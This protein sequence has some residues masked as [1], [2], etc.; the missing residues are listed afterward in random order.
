MDAEIASVPIFGLRHSTFTAKTQIPRHGRRQAERWN[1]NVLLVATADLRGLRNIDPYKFCQSTSWRP[2][3]MDDVSFVFLRNTPN[4]SS[5]IN[6]LQI[7]CSTQV[8]DPPVAASRSALHEF[9]L[10]SGELFF[11]LHRD[12]DAEKS[13]AQA[14]MLYRDDPNV[15]L[16][17]GLL[18][19]RQQ[20]YRGS[21]AGIAVVSGD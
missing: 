18:F 12:R 16:L 7:D 6:R 10:N 19:T 8:F 11:V 20:Q 1:L 9:Y 15:H 17:K 4:N 14:D 21:R 13:L 3:Y 5:W 2:I